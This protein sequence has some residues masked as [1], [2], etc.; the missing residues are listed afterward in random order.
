MQIHP[1]L[2]PTDK[3]RARSF[4]RS[5]E[6]EGTHFELQFGRYQ[7]NKIIKKGKTNVQVEE[8]EVNDEGKSEDEEI[9]KFFRVHCFF[10]KNLRTSVKIH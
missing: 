10:I 4:W 6:R 8:E 5:I 1:T 7:A 2:E 9:G 3:E